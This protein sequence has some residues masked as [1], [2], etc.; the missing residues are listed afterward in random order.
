MTVSIDARIVAGMGSAARTLRFQLPHLI[1]YLPEI[2]DCHCGSINLVLEQPLRV[3]NPDC[4][5]PPIRWSPRDPTAFERFSF[6]RV[7]F[8]CPAGTSP[9]RAWLY[10]AHDSPHRRDLFA[11]ELLA[12][13]IESARPD[14]NCR[15]HVAKQHMLSEIIVV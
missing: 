4:T 11:A 7:A 3:N 14:V 2:S 15:V 6:L 12:E 10:I 13:Y 5:T 8:E 1:K 9:H